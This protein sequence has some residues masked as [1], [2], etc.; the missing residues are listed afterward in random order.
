MYIF[1]LHKKN[2]VLCQRFFE[3]TCQNVF[4]TKFQKKEQSFWGP[5]YPSLSEF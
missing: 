3:I 5:R 4:L 2:P 1:I